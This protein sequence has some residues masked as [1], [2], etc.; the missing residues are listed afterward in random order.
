M[1]EQDWAIREN[2]GQA[3]EF[4]MELV[5]PQFVPEETARS[6]TFDVE[7]SVLGGKRRRPPGPVSRRDRRR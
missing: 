3:W 6:G 2:P 4:E 1:K 5:E 7:Y